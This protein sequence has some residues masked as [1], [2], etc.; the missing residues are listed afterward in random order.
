MIC[1][2]TRSYKYFAYHRLNLL[3]LLFNASLHHTTL[4]CSIFNLSFVLLRHFCY[5]REYCWELIAYFN[6]HSISITIDYYCHIEHK[7]DKRIA[8]YPWTNVRVL[9]WWM[10]KD[11]RVTLKLT[12][13]LMLFKKV[14]PSHS[15]SIVIVIWYFRYWLDYHSEIKAML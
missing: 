9:M 1:T 6:V 2:Q 13:L 3:L 4:Q 14:V 10:T 7:N 8:N 15:Q 5:N 11:F 12:S